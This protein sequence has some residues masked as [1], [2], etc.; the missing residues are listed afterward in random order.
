MPTP[1]S[2][3]PTQPSRIAILGAGGRGTHI[4][5]AIHGLPHLAT[6]V[7]V[8]DPDSAKVA[9]LAGACGVPDTGRF[10]SWQDFLASGLEVDGVVIATMDRDHVAPAVACLERG[11]H[12]IL[13]KPMAPDLAD[14]QRIEAAQRASGRFLTVCHSLRYQKA[15]RAVRDLV[16]GGAVGRIMTIDLLEQVGWAHQA[17]SFVRGNW[18]NSTR[19][20]PMILAKSCHD[21]DYLAFLTGTPALR[22]TSYGHLSY[23]TRANAPAGAPARCS[24]GCPHESTCSYSALKAYVYTDR[25]Q[26]PAALCSPTDHSMAAHLAA[27]QTGPYGRCVWQCDNDVVDHQVIALEFPG[28]IT[29]TFTMTAFTQEGGRRLRVHGTHGVLEFHDH[30]QEITV[31]T[32]ATGNVQRISVAREGGGHGGGDTRMVR[33]WLEALRHGDATGLVST[34]QESLRT[35]AMAFAA[36]RSRR[37]RRPV[38]LAELG[39]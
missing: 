8:A 26:W 5:G 27:V 25:V 20:A 13:E 35:H 31:T 4:G 6:V 10:A 11:W 28:E 15:F 9:Q 17:H 23:F 29:A 22:L 24:D 37:E 34:A 3:Q 16:V 30:A 12:V 14:C 19:S 39:V 32:F 7:A 1:T 2:A 33:D 36:E 21:L 38:E 18:G